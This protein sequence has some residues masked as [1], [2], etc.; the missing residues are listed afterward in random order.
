M[1]CVTWNMQGA[2]LTNESKWN[3]HILPMFLDNKS[4]GWTAA[5]A[6]VLQECGQPYPS[7]KPIKDY[8]RLFLG[9]APYGVDVY[10]AT[11]QA[12]TQS[13]G[14]TVWLLQIIWGSRC[15]LAVLSSVEP[16]AL[17]F[18]PNKLSDDARPAIGMVIGDLLLASVH[19]FS[20]SGNDAPSFV[21]NTAIV[22]SS[23]S[24]GS[25]FLAGDFNC[26]PSALQSKMTKS[27]YS[28]I[29]HKIWSSGKVTR[30]KSSTELDYAVS[31]DGMV[32]IKTTVLSKITASDH[33]PVQFT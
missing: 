10:Y 4:A 30:P 31:D 6:V 8:R 2:T 5:D 24:I 19:C 18:I 1:K 21:Q 9:R 15:N 12:G 17:S 28:K 25:W 33:Y 27:P 13:R 14:R 23:N 16:A 29:A 20:G 7:M 32:G 3:Q 22:A 26:D 11:V